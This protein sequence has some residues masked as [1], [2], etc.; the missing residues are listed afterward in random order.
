VTFFPKLTNAALAATLTLVGFGAV[1]T[2]TSKAEAA[3]NI[4]CPISQARRVITTSLPGGWWTTPIVN[5][6]TNT[7]VS[8]IGGKPALICQYGSAGSVQRNAP[9]GQTCRARTGGFT[10]SSRPQTFSSGLVD[11]RQTFTVDLDDGNTRGQGADIWFQAETSD[12]LYLVP[13][14]GARLGVG[15]RSNRGLDGCSRARFTKNRVSLR[16]IPISSYVCAKTG[17]GRI[18]QFRLNDIIGSSPKTLKIGYTT[19]R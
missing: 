9:N 12:L 10:C 16:D 14:G 1:D 4:N 18:S 19:W 7:K 6:L 2:L 11:L 5:R 17:E 3:E 13:R 15:D 8:K